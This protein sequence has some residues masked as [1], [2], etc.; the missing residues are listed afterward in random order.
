[1]TQL[2]ERSDDSNYLLRKHL[3]LR[4]IP[5]LLED[6]R[7]SWGN[8]LTY[9]GCTE[10]HAVAVVNSTVHDTWDSRVMGDWVHKETGRLVELWIRTD[11][12]QTLEAAREILRKYEEVL[13]YDDV[14]TYG[15]RRRQPKLETRISRRRQ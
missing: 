12:E 15:P 6:L 4:E 14:L 9:I 2:L 3:D 7:D 5:T 8:P 13:R 11:D 1:M 10:S